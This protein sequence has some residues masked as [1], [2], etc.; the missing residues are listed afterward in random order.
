MRHAK[1]AWDT[2]AADF[3]R[4]LN[5]RGIDA[6]ERMAD[7]LGDEGRC[8]DQIVSS[9]AL[10]ARSTIQPVIDACG[11]DQANVTID[12]D[13][14]HAGIDQWLDR[15]RIL[16]AN[17]VL[18]CGHNPGLDDLVIE[19]LGRVPRLTRSGKL[20]TTAAIA[21]LQT[22]GDWQSLQPAQ[23]TLVVLKRPR[24]R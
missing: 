17:R 16:T 5:G 22:S 9:G 24:G 3:D 18:I 21:H 7:W 11:I 14:Y 23:A 6:A 15:L 12:D 1:S 19:L 2:G 4:P 8:P 10:R 13:L 20:M